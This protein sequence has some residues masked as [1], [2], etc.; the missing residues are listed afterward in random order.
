MV[1]NERKGITNTVKPIIRTR[2]QKLKEKQD[3]LNRMFT[4]INTFYSTY[5]K[6]P[7]SLSSDIHELQM[8]VFL[9][10]IRENISTG[11]IT[12]KAVQ[13]QLTW[14]VHEPAHWKNRTFN[15]EDVKLMVLIFGLFPILMLGTQ[16]YFNY[17][18]THKQCYETAYAFTNST[19]RLFL[20]SYAFIHRQIS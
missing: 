5:K 16:F 4:D 14:F 3:A 6:E 1:I 10:S 18:L 2:S 9:K 11:Q 17:C 19:E 7:S 13:N 12:E 8:A 20:D 15:H